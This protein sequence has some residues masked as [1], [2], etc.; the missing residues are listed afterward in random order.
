MHQRRCNEVLESIGLGAVIRHRGWEDSAR[1]GTGAVREIALVPEADGKVVLKLYPGDSVEQARDFFAGVNINHFLSLQQNGWS[2]RP[3]LHFAH[4]QKNVYW[5][6]VGLPLSRYLSWWQE[7][8]VLIKKWE[9]EHFELLFDK[10]KSARQLSETDLLELR[11]LFTDSS[12]NSLNLCPGVEVFYR[13]S[14]GDA[15][16]ADANAAFADTVREQIRT[17]FR[18]WEQVL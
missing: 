18:T 9:R 4:I 14:L 12:R 15:D 10:L 1:L 3:N 17:A 11:R 8:P 13:W 5:A 2:L 16:E 6:S 7:R